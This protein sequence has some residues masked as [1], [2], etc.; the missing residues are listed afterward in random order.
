MTS[1]TLTEREPE[2]TVK[3]DDESTLTVASSGRTAIIV[4]LIIVLVAMLGLPVRSWLLQRAEIRGLETQIE[5][6]RTDLRQLRAERDQWADSDFIERQARERLNYVYPGDVGLVVVG[7]Q[8][9]PETDEPD[10]EWFAKLWRSVES[11]DGQTDADAEAEQ[12]PIRPDA[13]K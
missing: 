3:V 2:A 5:E 6:V 10:Q 12:I 11:A 8:D 1:P 7:G 4:G 9:T 13:P